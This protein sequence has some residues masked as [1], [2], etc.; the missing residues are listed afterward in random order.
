MPA[1]S[2]LPALFFQVLLL[3]FLFL[4]VMITSF[5]NSGKEKISLNDITLN[6]ILSANA[7]VTVVGW[8]G[9][10]DGG[11][12]GGDFGSGCGGCCGGSGGGGG[13]SK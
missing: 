3:V 13:G 7:D 6:T 12:I 10:L 9:C 5:F 8:V 1:I 11:N 4:W 2:T